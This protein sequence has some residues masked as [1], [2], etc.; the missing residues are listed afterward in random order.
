VVI[1]FSCFEYHPYETNLK[2]IE[3]NKNAK[4]IEAVKQSLFK[5]DTIRFAWV[6]DTQ[7][8]YEETESFVKDINSKGNIDFVL[9]GGDITYFGMKS[10]FIWIEDILE[11]LHIP[12]I[13]LVGNHDLLGTGEIIYRHIYGEPDFS[14]ILNRVMFICLNT[15]TA[16]PS[17][18]V[19]DYNF[20]AQNISDS[21]TGLYDYTIVAMH[22]APTG[23]FASKTSTTAQHFYNSISKAKNLLFCLYAHYHTIIE[24]DVFND[25]TMHLVTDSM[26]SRV[27]FIFTLINGN[28]TYTIERF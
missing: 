15:N 28:Y 20:I 1:L 24:R 6:G 16:E 2:G 13:C 5:K 10:E 19:P 12:H 8:H 21:T 17:Y 7:K 3:G 22:A 18:K 27:Y 4:S 9:H 26:K 14:F 25:G 11:K 23:L